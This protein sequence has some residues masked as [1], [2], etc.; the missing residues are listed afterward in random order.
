MV[1]LYGGAIY[2]LNNDEKPKDYDFIV[3]T[4]E[5]PNKYNEKF[6]LVNKE[7]IQKYSINSF[8]GLKVITKSGSILDLAVIKDLQKE[9]SKFIELN[10]DNIFYNVLY[11]QIIHINDDVNKWKEFHENK[12]IIRINNNTHPVLGVKR[13]EKRIQ[14]ALTYNSNVKA[15]NLKEALPKDIIF[16]ITNTNRHLELDYLKTHKCICKRC[17][18]TEFGIE[19]F[20]F[21][22]FCQ[23]CGLPSDSI[24]NLIKK[25]EKETYSTTTLG[26]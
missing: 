9:A 4:E 18:C 13:T 17:G 25:K 10:S 23:N 7:N 14:N 21:Q 20:M 2:C 12:K 22:T 3:T 6:L 5:N 15:I 19:P 8:G 16:M 11:N 26:K 24:R 1:Y